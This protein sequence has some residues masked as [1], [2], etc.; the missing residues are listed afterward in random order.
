MDDALCMVAGFVL[1]EA[2]DI[3][4]GSFKVTD[5]HLV[6][7]I[8]GTNRGRLLKDLDNQLYRWTAEVHYVRAYGKLALE[9]QS[10]G[11]HSLQAVP[12]SSLLGAVL[13]F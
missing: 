11:L 1:G 13:E 6:V 10:I 2:Q 4:A 12:N 8:G 7:S 5:T 3:V 9:P